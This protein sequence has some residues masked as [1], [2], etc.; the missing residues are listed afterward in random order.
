MDDD[1]N[2]LRQVRGVLA[3]AATPR[4]SP[5][6]WARCPVWSCWTSR[7]PAPAGIELMETHPAL[8]SLPVVLISE[9]EN[10]AVL[11]GAASRVFCSASRI[12][13]CTD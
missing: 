3:V 7:C 12:R 4:S 13:V 1:P 5:P 9:P 10:A 6:S 8:A 11:R 2:S